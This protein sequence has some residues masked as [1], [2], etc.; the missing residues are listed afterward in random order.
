MQKIN[1]KAINFAVMFVLALLM[2]YFTLENTSAATVNIAPGVS[3]SL[4][5]AALVLIASGLGACGAWL[6]AGWSDK[7]RGDE[8]RELEDTK[9]RIKELELDYNRL[10]AKQNN[11]LPFMSFSGEKE[12]EIDKDAA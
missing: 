12:L 3:G 5:I 11:L 9:N 8:I 2:V 6:F 4:P 7:L 10:K 1:L